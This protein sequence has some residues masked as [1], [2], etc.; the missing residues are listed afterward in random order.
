MPSYRHLAVAPCNCP[1][2]RQRR[3]SNRSMLLSA[4]Y[5]G[6]NA[7]NKR[8][9]MSSGS[10]AARGVI[11]R[12]R[13]W[14]TLSKICRQLRWPSIPKNIWRTAGV[15]CISR[16]RPDWLC[17]SK[18]DLP[19]CSSMTLASPCPEA[20]WVSRRK[21]GIHPSSAYGAVVSPSRVAKKACS[22][23]SPPISSASDSC[24]RCDCALIA[25]RSGK[26]CS[27]VEGE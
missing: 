25:A 7:A 12:S 27:H 10:S 18:N 2:L 21:N 26:S 17:V 11:P 24:S 15:G 19:S 4:S 9:S 23:K 22:T 8:R 20:G 3:S 13:C 5:H 6:W 16:R 14:R 1:S